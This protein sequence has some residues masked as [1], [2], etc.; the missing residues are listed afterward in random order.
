MRRGFALVAAG[1]LVVLATACS[2]EDEQP[3]PEVLS[4]S[5]SSA[6]TGSPAPSGLPHSGAPAVD[7]PMPASVLS[8]DPCQILTAEQVKTAL[9]DNAS[10]GVRHDLDELG[11]RC[12]WSN[13]E[14]RASF[15]VTFQTAHKQGLSTTYANVK[16]QAAAFNE[17]API[18][19]YPAVTY[20]DQEAGG[21][22]CTAM[23]GLSDEYAV[24]VTGTIGRDGVNR[25]GGLLKGC[26]T[27]EFACREVGVEGCCCAQAVSP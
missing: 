6:P 22:M 12:R 27:S 20:Q 19:G 1:S 13:T 18:D 8:G 3:E 21:P 2:T 11:P 14:A 26:V 4:A 17:V 5:P 16:P 25:P 10:S 9:G 24:S 23:V 15:V 7:N